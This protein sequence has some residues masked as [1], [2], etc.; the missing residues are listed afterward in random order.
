MVKR[1][2]R[3]VAQDT[4]MTGTVEGG[5]LVAEGREYDPDT[6]TFLAPTE[7]TKIVCVGLNYRDHAEESQLP[8]PE[9]PL[10]FLKPPSALVG[11]HG[12]IR[13]PTQSSRVE[14]EGELAVVI[15]APCSRVPEQTALDYVA[16]YTIL[17]DVTARDIQLRE[18]Q[19]TRAKGFDT[20][21]P[22]GPWL[23]EGIDASDLSIETLLNGEVRQSSS[24]R[25]LIFP[26][27]QIVSYISSVMTLEPGD[28]IA[29]GTPAGVG[30]MR[31]GDTVEVRIEGIGSLINVAA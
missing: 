12:S 13:L 21:A 19:W 3:F 24:T 9:E 16:G 7:P 14:Y 28:I 10:L 15:R 23:V 4:T 2:A 22:C 11:H 8:L 6:V 27:P 1:K 29:T 30:I 5:L 25:Q 20:F 18:S 31:P 17:N 26:V